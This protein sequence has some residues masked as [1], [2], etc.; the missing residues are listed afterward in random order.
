MQG[1]RQG[2]R[3]CNGAAKRWQEESL[4]GRKNTVAAFRFVPRCVLVHA[5]LLLG[6]KHASEKVAQTGGFRV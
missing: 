6:R 4:V 1:E 3:K 5:R 2:R